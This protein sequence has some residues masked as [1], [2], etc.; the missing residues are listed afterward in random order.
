MADCAGGDPDRF[1][2][3]LVSG[4]LSISTSDWAMGALEWRSAMVSLPPRSSLGRFGWALNMSVSGPGQ[5]VSMSVCAMVGISEVSVGRSWLPR[6]STMRAFSAA[7]PFA[8]KRR[9]SAW[10]LN[11]S[12][13]RP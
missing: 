9:N 13:P 8:S 4:P 2:L 7:L 11:G 3:V 12:T 5:N 1:A 10:L 6:M